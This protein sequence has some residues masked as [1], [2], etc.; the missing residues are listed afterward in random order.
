VNIK[1][2]DWAEVTFNSITSATTGTVNISAGC[3]MRTDTG[4]PS[5]TSPAPTKILTRLK[6]GAGDFLPKLQTAVAVSN[7]EKVFMKLTY[8]Q[9][10]YGTDG[11]VFYDCTSATYVVATSASDSS[12]L[13]YIHIADIIIA[14]SVMT[15][16]PKFPG[17]VTAPTL[18]L[19]K[20][21][22][23]SVDTLYWTTVAN[24]STSVTIKRGALLYFN[25][26]RPVAEQSAVQQTL[27]LEWGP[28]SLQ[29]DI[30][31]TGI[32]DLDYLW[33][34]VSLSQAQQL[35][36]TSTENPLGD[37]HT[38]WV[39]TVSNEVLAPATIE[40]GPISDLTTMEDDIVKIPFAQIDGGEIIQLHKGIMICPP[41]FSLA[42]PT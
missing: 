33:V 29:D 24:S 37:G 22:T 35:F 42:S 27:Q 26:Y 38:H 39:Y 36:D 7:G 17:V 9:S 20:D 30:E 34:E 6:D 41:F 1:A 31:I 25:Y 21:T 13:S 5:G 40:H 32:S 18:V 8:T 12:T 3:V 11:T 16:K 10:S 4:T 19:P 23:S 2:A 28:S 14:D 15:I